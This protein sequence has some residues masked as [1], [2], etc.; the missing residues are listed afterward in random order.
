[1]QQIRVHGRRE[2]DEGRRSYLQRARLPKDLLTVKHSVQVGFAREGHEP[3]VLDGIADDD[4]IE[5][6]L[7]GGLRLWSSAEHLRSDFGLKTSRDAS[8]TEMLEVTTQLPLGGQSRGVGDWVI[9]GLKVLGVDIAGKITDFVADKVETQLAPGPGLYRCS[10]SKRGDLQPARKLDGSR[11]TLVFLH[12]T[13]SS[14]DGSF[15][16]LWNGAAARVD[17]LAGYYGDNIL[18]LQH[19][20]LTQSPIENAC[21]LLTALAKVLPPRS[22]L[23]LVSHSRGGLVGELVARGNRVGGGS[24]DQTDLQIIKRNGR[25]ADATGLRDLRDLLDKQRYVVSRFV[26]VAC[27]T[28]GTTLA[29]GRLD[30]YLSVILNVLETIPGLRESVVFDTFAS[31]LAAVVKKRTDPEE[32]PGLEAMMPQSALVRMLNRPDVRTDANLRILGGDIEGTGF[33]GRLKA[34]VTDLYY[35]EDHDLVVNTP[36]MFGGTERA[37]TVR[38]WVDTGG[39]VNH[40]NYFAN[41]DTA[42]RLVKALT[43]ETAPQFQ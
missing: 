29:S 22:E 42:G 19:R 15:G 39:R 35:R 40:F 6:E 12:G 23:H 17:D 14:T 5:L 20:T 18:A 25:A 8:G 38:Y 21:D 9:R 28:R 16:E 26:R 34:F 3:T 1:M 4:L 24:F 37:K 11:P 27:P 32:L 7:D 10:P 30:K 13:G 2:S 36:A 33:W 43:D 31:L 41:A